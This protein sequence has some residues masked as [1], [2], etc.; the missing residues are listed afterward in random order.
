MMLQDELVNTLDAVLS[1]KKSTTPYSSLNALEVSAERE[2]ERERV[3]V[4]V[5]VCV[6]RESERERERE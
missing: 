1:G 2:R 6:E 4:C 3:C 5:C